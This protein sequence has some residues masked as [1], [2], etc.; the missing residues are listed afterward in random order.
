MCS[1]AQE[2]GSG[3]RISSALP[4]VRLTPLGRC[5]DTT[6]VPS[7]HARNTHARPHFADVLRCCC[8]ARWPLSGW[9][10]HR[11][12]RPSSRR[13]SRRVPPGGSMRRPGAWQR[14]LLDRYCVACHNERLRTAGLTLDHARRDPHRRCAGRLGDRGPQVAGRRDAAVAAPAAGRGD[15]R[16]VHRLAGDGARPGRRGRSESR[17]HGGVSSAQPDRVPPCRARPPRPGDRRRGA[18]AGR[19]GQ[20]R[21][22]QHRRRARRFADAAGALPRRRPQDQPGG[23]RAPGA[24]G[25]RRGLPS[26]ERLA[27]GRLGGGDAV[28]HPR[29]R[30]VSPCVP[31]GCRLHLPRPPRPQRRRQPGRL[32]GAAHAG[33]EPGRR[34]GPGV[35]RRRAAARQRAARQRRVPRLAGPATDHR[36]RLGVPPAGHG[37]A[38]RVARD[39]RAEDRGLPGDA[40]AAL[41]AALHQ[42][43]RRRYA[44]ASHTWEASPSPGRSRRAAP[45][46][47]RR[48]RAAGASSSAGRPT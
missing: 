21:V 42:H 5:P 14:A 34:S 40:A 16:P 11:S 33:G 19:R 1:R 35:H 45:R 22:R 6:Q 32:R 28:R 41:L 48:P 10:K 15:L 20:L 9:P 39:V 3:Q 13:R 30:C 43:H 31:G 17:A 27:A 46:P 44:G 18:A 7:H 29:R 23:G 25:Y 4:A 2:T 24:V 26:R 38:A 47:W 12:A 36:R 8:A 37:R